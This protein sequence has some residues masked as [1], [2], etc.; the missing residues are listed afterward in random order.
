MRKRTM[1]MDVVERARR[2]VS[3][4]PMAVSGQGGHNAT[5]HVAAV[6]WNGF[7]LTEVVTLSLLREWN[8]G[9]RPPWSEAELVHKVKSV[10]GKSHA[11][12]RG[13]L[14][15]DKVTSGEWPV[16]RVAGRRDM[17]LTTPAKAAFCPMVLRRIAANV[18]VAD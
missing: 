3:K 15:K 6:L 18:K 11:D 2:Y 8:L 10:A 9:C 17:C 14:L 5:F 16:A 7:G 13:H 12:P 4:C 1:K